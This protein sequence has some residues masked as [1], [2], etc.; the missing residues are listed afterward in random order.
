MKLKTTN[1]NYAAV[2]VEVTKTVTF[3]NCDNVHGAICLGNTVVAGKDVVEGTKGVY[4]PLE[5]KL[6]DTYRFHN[7]LNRDKT[8]NSDETKAGYFEKHGRVRAV[9]FRK[10]KSQGLFM[11]LESLDFVGK[12]LEFNVGDEFNEIDGVEICTKYIPASSRTPGAPGS[13]KGKGK[14]PKRETRLIDGQ[15]KFHTDT[16]QLYKNAHRLTPETLVS[17]TYKIHGTSGI[18]SNTLVKRKLSWL[19]RLARFVGIP[20]VETEYDNIYSS[21]K[22]VKNGDIKEHNHF[23]C[24]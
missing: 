9:P 12:G 14:S 21:R 24:Q 16:A 4:F 15:F 10:N 3:P 7:N 23:F 11:P 8:T 18:S 13:K 17:I 2:I 1:T 20:V 6:S 19:D 5:S 22:V